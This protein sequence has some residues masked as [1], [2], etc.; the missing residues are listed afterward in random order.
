MDKGIIYYTNNRL[1]KLDYEKM[2]PFIVK[3]SI[4]DSG[5]PIT[6]CSLKPMDFGN[7]VV[8]NKNPGPITMFEQILKALETSREK[9]VFFC[10]HD[11]IYHQSHFK[12]SPPR[13]DTF[14]YNTNVWRCHLK[15]NTCVTY[16][17]LRSVSGICV[18][19]KLAAKH[20]RK[21]LK[22]IFDKGYDKISGRS[23]PKWARIM[24]YE[25]G[26]SVT[27]GGFT[28]EKIDDW[29]SKHPNIDIRH[30]ECVTASQMTLDRFRRKPKNFVSVSIDEVPG[31]NLKKM[32]CLE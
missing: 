28:Y 14:Y 32:F 11:V 31:W 30:K 16:K 15:T 26:K 17:N 4:L 10:E 13:D 19:R 20:Y 7:N 29:R 27:A 8:L 25:P 12:F 22:Y 1:E 6:S 3:K 23:S 21:R 18:N 9:Y 24:G 2:L 5:L